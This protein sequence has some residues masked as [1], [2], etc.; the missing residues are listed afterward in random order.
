MIKLK[1]SDL[2]IKDVVNMADGKNLGRIIDVELSEIGAINY[3]VVEKKRFFWQIFSSSEPDIT[4][5]VSQINKIGEDVIL[6]EV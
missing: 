2:Q 1:L 5:K 6:V 3:F 4:I